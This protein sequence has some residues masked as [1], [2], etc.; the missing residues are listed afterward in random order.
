NKI[1][2]FAGWRNRLV[3][4]PVSFDVPTS[5]LTPVDDLHARLRFS[6]TWEKL[7]ETNQARF[8]FNEFG[9]E[10]GTKYTILDKMMAEIP[11]KDNYGATIQDDAFG[12]LAYDISKTPD[13][14]LNAANYH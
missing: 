4:H 5:F 3:C 12:L 14:V 13:T 9:T 6:R 11:G 1:P 7:P 8:R 10:R 2:Q